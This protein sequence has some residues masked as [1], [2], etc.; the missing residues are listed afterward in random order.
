MSRMTW[1]ATAAIV[2][3]L[4]GGCRT[5]KSQEDQVRL[6]RELGA[7][8]PLWVEV[9]CTKRGKPRFKDYSVLKLPIEKVGWALARL[10]DHCRVY[11]TLTDGTR[12]ADLCDIRFRSRDPV[13]EG[14]RCKCVPGRYVLE[15]GYPTSKRCC[16]K[17][18]EK[19]YCR[20]LYESPPPTPEETPPITE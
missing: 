14:A 18:P 8:V 12:D 7:N 16:E 17:Y 15:E 11:G 9:E 6:Q 13:V 4:L 10:D 3:A 2:L 19:V 20:K 1:L 5:T